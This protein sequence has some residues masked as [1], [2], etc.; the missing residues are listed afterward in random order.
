MSAWLL[1]HEAQVRLA[2]FLS[3]FAV[4]II[5]QRVHPLRSMPGGWRRSATN[6]ALIVIDTVIL[7]VAFP[8]LAFDLAV[9]LDAPGDG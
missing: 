3:L 8:L 4:F 1:G 2:V 6:L 7:R 9:N 5:L